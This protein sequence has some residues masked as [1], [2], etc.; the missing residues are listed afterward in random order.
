MA[1]P[2]WGWVTW[3]CSLSL[4]IQGKQQSLWVLR[5]RSRSEATGLM[6]QRGAL[7]P[8]MHRICAESREFQAAVS[9]TQ[10]PHTWQGTA[11]LALFYFFFSL[12][13]CFMGLSKLSSG[14]IQNLQL[15]WVISF[16]HRGSN[17]IFQPI[18]FPISCKAGVLAS[19]FV[20]P[21]LTSAAHF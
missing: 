18:P 9:H 8:L 20:A 13:Y 5:D 1:K 11:S 10:I 12:C 21:A 3:V 16:P 14:C 2:G 17:C 4:Y 6:F 15:S 7:L 19:A